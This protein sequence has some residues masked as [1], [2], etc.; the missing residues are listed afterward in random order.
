VGISIGNGVGTFQAPAL[1]QIPYNPK[2]FASASDLN[3]D[4]SFDL[5]EFGAASSVGVTTQTLSVWQS[6]PAISFAAPRLDFATQSAG[7][8]SSPASITLVNNGNAALSISKITATGSFAQ[9]NNCK[10]SIATGQSCIVNVSFNL[11]SPGP[12]NGTLTFSDNA[13]PNTQ[14]LVLTGM[15]NPSDFFITASP[16][17]NSV[18]AGATATYT[19]T[20]APIDGFT[21]TV[22]LACAGAPTKATCTLS[23]TSVTLDGS[24]SVDVTVTVTTTAPTTA[25]FITPS[26]IDNTFR[27]SPLWACIGFVPLVGLLWPR[28]HKLVAIA[29]FGVVAFAL[30]ACGGGSNSGGGRGTTPGTPQGAYNMKISGTD[31]SLVHTSTI[32]LTVQ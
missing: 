25:F 4:G 6:V 23:K 2:G 22:Q 13:Y 31:G 10:S 27:P 9:T 20:L 7:T 1:F 24:S 16:S 15:G 17:S 5:V 21:G 32:T 3:A 12:A 26:P 8:S 11:T 14:V 30:V 18:A 19:A 29:A 28:R